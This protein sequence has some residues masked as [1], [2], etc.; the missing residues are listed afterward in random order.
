MSA[1]ARADEGGAH[2]ARRGHRGRGPTAPQP[3]PPPRARRQADI[4]DAEGIKQRQILEAEGEAEA[5]RA[6]A[7]AERFRQL[8]VA[9]GE[10]EAIRSVYQAI[11]D[12]NPDAGLITIK[13]LEALQAMANGSATKIILPTE[14]A[15]IA[16]A[17]AGIT[18]TIRVDGTAPGA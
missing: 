3:S 18:E 13:Y 5:I 9:Q 8:T 12:G 17:I 10:A 4:L 15:G 1:D 6:V 16:G 14:L 2:P 7:D 11:H